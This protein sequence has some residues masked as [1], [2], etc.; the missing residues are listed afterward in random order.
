MTNCKYMI[1]S[2]KNGINRTELYNEACIAILKDYMN[3]SYRNCE[4][5]Y[6]VSY[7][8]YKCYKKEKVPEE[9]KIKP[10]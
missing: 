5:V 4:N 9:F 3:D 2:Q 8:I 1:F 10:F 6:A 7:D